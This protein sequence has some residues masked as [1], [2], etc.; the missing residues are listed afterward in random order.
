MAERQ[1]D[2]NNPDRLR[3]QAVSALE[4]D[5]NREISLRFLERLRERDAALGLFDSGDLI[6]MAQSD[7]EC[8]IA[9]SIE[10]AP[11]TE[12]IIALADAFHH[13]C[14]SFAREQKYQL[15]ADR[16]PQASLISACMRTACR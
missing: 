6:R 3:D 9:R 10:A 4:F 5:A 15:I 14:E 1:A 8:R 11:R 7:L 12:S 13:R 16:H 2:R